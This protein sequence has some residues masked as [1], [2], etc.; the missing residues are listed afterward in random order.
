M[1]DVSGMDSGWEFGL[2]D[3]AGFEVGNAFLCVPQIHVVK[4]PVA[5]ATL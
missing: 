3:G 1:S 4:A 2:F 5:S